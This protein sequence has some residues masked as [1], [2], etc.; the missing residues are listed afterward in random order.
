MTY[1]DKDVLDGC[2]QGRSWAINSVIE[3]ITPLIRHKLFTFDNWEDVRQHCIVE[4]L[5]TLEKP[6]PVRNLWG[7]IRKITIC[8]VIDFNRKQQAQDRIFTQLNHDVPDKSSASAGYNPGS[9]R[10]PTDDLESTNLFLYI[11]QR[12]GPACQEIIQELFMRGLSYTDLASKLDIS[13][14]NLRVRLKRCRDK[15]RL[16]RKQLTGE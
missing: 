4:I 15:A 14:G 2:R 11:F 8:T 9:Y 6:E 5:D 16:L 10:G 7:L 13:E 12:L 3:F 1:T